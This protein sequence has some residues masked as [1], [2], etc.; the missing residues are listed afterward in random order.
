MAQNKAVWDKFMSILKDHKPPVSPLS[1][2][3]SLDPFLVQ[4]LPKNVDDVPD[5]I[6]LS[7]DEQRRMK[8]SHMGF[9]E[10]VKNSGIELNYVAGSRG[11][12]ST[13]AEKDLGSVV[14][15]L[16][17]LR[18]TGCTLPAEILVSTD[19]VAKSEMCTEIL[20]PLNATCI[21]TDS[22]IGRNHP[23]LDNNRYLNKLFALIFSSFDDNLFLDADNLPIIDPTAY[24]YNEPY[25]S[26]GL[27]AWPDFWPSS[28]SHRH[29]DITSTVLPPVNGT[30]ESG[31][32][33]ISKTRHSET[34]LLA[35]YYNFYGPEYY[36]LLESQG[37][38]GFGDKGMLSQH[39][40]TPCS[41]RFIANPYLTNR[42][43]PERSPSPERVLLPRP[44][45]HL[46][47]WL[48][49]RRQL[50]RSRH[51]PI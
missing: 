37:A 31:Q 23:E 26:R 27:V 10:K 38:V 3:K 50:P 25:S 6:N 16:S 20:A 24:F 42:I 41:Y 49:G 47:P 34:L 18:R 14:M 12:V 32:L 35:F 46:C 40:N 9:V 11:I 22:S 44:R 13:A 36:Y 8:E 33:L 28:I 4:D 21:A 45:I 30:V 7:D 15:T 39:T 5:V 48:L 29:K 1:I 19:T 17:M 2:S 51:G 43:L